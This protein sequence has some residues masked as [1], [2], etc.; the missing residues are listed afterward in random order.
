M[1]LNDQ[2]SPLAAEK[3]HDALFGDVEVS[4]IIEVAGEDELL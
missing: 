2:F 1:Q 4:E 3:L